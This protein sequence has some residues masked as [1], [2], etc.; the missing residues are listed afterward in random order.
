MCDTVCVNADSS[1]S[2][3]TSQNSHPN[4]PASG[5]SLCSN[6]VIGQSVGQSV[7]RR[8]ISLQSSS[9]ETE[10][11]TIGLHQEAA[12]PYYHAGGAQFNLVDI[13]LEAYYRIGCS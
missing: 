6:Q 5:S 1:A 2:G 4:S 8:L 12:F 11:K 9:E 7:S 13:I 3:S 10:K